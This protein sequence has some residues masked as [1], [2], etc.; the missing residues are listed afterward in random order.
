MNIKHEPSSVHT[1]CSF[2]INNHEDD[3]DDD[4]AKNNKK[5]KQ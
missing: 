3:D 2:T 5:K 4:E 1:F